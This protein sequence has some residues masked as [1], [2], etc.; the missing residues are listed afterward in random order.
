M[1]RPLNKKF[2]GNRNIGTTGTGDDGIGGQGVASATITAAGGG[3]RTGDAVIFSAPQLPTGVTATGT[4]VAQSTNPSPQTFTITVVN[5]GGG[6]VFVIDGVN[7][8]VLDLVRGGVYTFDQSAAS[9]TNHQ[10]AFK[11]ADGN[12]YT[13]GIVTTGT[14]GQAGANT[15]FTV[16][17][18]APSSLRYYCV[19]HGNYM[20]NTITVTGFVGAV[21][22]ITITESGSGYTSAPTVDITGDELIDPI[23][24]AVAVLT[25]DTGAP[26]SATNQENAISISAFVPGGSSAVVGDI[27]KQSSSR[28]YRVTTAQG[29]GRCDL[30]A[31]APAAG[32]MTM[33]AVDSVGGTYYVT[34]LTARR[35]LIIQGDRTGTQFVTGATGITIPW[36][37]DAAVLNATVRILNA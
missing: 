7:K 16:P 28:A 24:T 18:N 13:N 29:T 14:P 31:A 1:G 34:K 15:V 37:F 25:V 5:D 9:N 4:I 8:P 12:S 10:L 26:G 20:G 22:T 32:E 19:A 27:V 3:Y 11:D 33:T 21:I 2:F 36:S 17:A 23:A 35:A 30:V 6:N